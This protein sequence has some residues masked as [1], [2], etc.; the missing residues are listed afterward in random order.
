VILPSVGQAL[1]VVV[2]YNHTELVAVDVI[3]VVP[4][5]K[6][7]IMGVFVAEVP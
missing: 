5:L 1:V 2:E 4:I 3:V 7:L 6:M